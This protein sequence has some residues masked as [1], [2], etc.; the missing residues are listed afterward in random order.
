MWQKIV[1]FFMSIIAFF[2]SL[3][4]L[5]GEK[6]LEG[7]YWNVSYGSHAR[8]VVDIYY[9]AGKTE[10][11]LLLSLHGG[12]WTAGSKEDTRGWSRNMVNAGVVGAAMNYRM[13]D[14]QG[15]AGYADML[16]DITAAIG[17][18]ISHAA[19]RGVTITKVALLGGSAGAHLSLLY[20]YTR[21]AE[22]PLNIEF[23]V[24]LSGPADFLDE[25]FYTT[26]N[27]SWISPLV[28]KLIGEQVSITPENMALYE[29]ALRAASPLY[30]ATADSPAT[31]IAH[32][33]HD[34]IVPFSN[35][36]ALQLR[37]EELHAP[38]EYFVFPNSEHGLESD[39][40]V[41]DAFFATLTNDYVIP[42]L[43]QH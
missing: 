29:Q 28:G 15:A 12:G 38:F 21:Q 36:E 6:P 23:V 16:D 40:D 13:L 22:C 33:V 42:V 30:Q 18:V 17:A 9:P 8:Q 39:P 11:G 19:A 2:M 41:L 43:G 20:A 26:P 37:L 32:G 3:F 14:N 27:A 24:S 34:S 5:G 10:V 7:E 35:A 31:L 25:A 1:S 4:G